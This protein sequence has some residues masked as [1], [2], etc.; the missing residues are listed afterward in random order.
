MSALGRAARLWIIQWTNPLLPPEKSDAR[1]KICEG[2]R[3]FDEKLRRC[4][5]CQCYVDL[6]ALLRTEDCP[7]KKWPP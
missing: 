7:A 5:V 2:C 6:K 4:Q 1:I 3:F